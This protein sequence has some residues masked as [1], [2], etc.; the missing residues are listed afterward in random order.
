[1]ARVPVEEY[2]NIQRNILDRVDTDS[3][4]SD[5]LKGIAALFGLD[6]LER[7]MKRK[8]EILDDNIE[9]IQKEEI[10]RNGRNDVLW[11]KRNKVLEDDI[12]IKKTL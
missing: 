6:V 9:A 2:Y 3:I 8:D 12:L 10:I 5:Q 7:L 11:K 1:M 4:D